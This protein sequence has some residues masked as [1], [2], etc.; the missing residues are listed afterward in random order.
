M[1]FTHFIDGVPVNEPNGWEDFEQEVSR[2]FD[3]RMVTVQ[4]P[5]DATF[6]KGGYK[7]LR[8]MFM[9]SDCGIVVYEAYDECD[10]VRILLVRANII[11][12]D[13]EWNLNR[14]E[15]SCSLVDDGIMAR[16]D[17][18]RN[19]PISPGADESKNT[20]PIAPV[21]PVDGVGVDVFT[22]TTGAYLGTRAAFDWLACMQ[23]AV[24]YMTDSNVTLVSS[25]YNSLPDD[26]RWSLLSGFQL[27]T[28]AT[29]DNDSRI[30]YTFEKLFEEMAKTYNL[31]MVVQRDNDG[32]PFVVIEQE[33][34]LFST[35]VAADFPNTD[36]LVQSVDRDQLWATVVVGSSD[37]VKNQAAT[38]SL[39]YLVL[40][41]FSEEKF[42]FEGSCN[43]DSELDLM[44]E[45]GWD[46][47]LIQAVIAGNTNHDE[48]VFFI[49]Y[50]RILNRATQGTYLNPNTLPA[51][52]NEAAL[53]VNVLNRYT[54]PSQVGTYYDSIDASFEALTTSTSAPFTDVSPNANSS[55]NI[56]PS[57]DNVISN[58]GGNYA[59]SLF[60]APSQGYYVFRVLR[61]YQILSNTFGITALQ[62]KLYSEIN[63]RHLDGALAVISQSANINGSFAPQFGVFTPAGFY[64]HVHSAG[65]NMNA[66]DI[67]DVRFRFAT[68]SAF[69]PS[70]GGQAVTA[71]DNP[72]SIFESTFVATGGGILTN[73][74]TEAARIIVYQFDRFTPATRWANILADPSLAIRVAPDDNLKVGHISS[75][76]R[77]IL[78]GTTTYE[79]IC[80]RDQK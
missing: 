70:G 41:G 29:G 15:V 51:L 65:F 12:A 67:V 68:S 26:E 38:L 17:N 75:A 20:I 80:K 23:H 7:R 45:F 50:N 11:L 42:H 59:P 25:W 27:R 63:I 22:T 73:V 37:A 39:P 64:T 72:S 40:Q 43:T 56:L 18:N 52:Y 33:E 55:F 76:V 61:R 3:K 71:R 78:K 47:N 66:G 49:Q 58:P 8:E 2:D 48:K 53:N 57:F 14:C 16:V 13:C 21:I 44:R 79:L 31:W 6:T 77:N 28:A 74:D 34:A 1:I 10:G 24:Q 32:T 9:E 19:I 30:T 62:K 69:G 5:G 46:T 60:T 36:N 54:L 4:Y 35:A